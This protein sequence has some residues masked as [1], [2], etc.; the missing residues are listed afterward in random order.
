M[1]R[2]KADTPDNERMETLA[3]AA[4][5]YSMHHHRE[6]LRMETGQPP[7]GEAE[8]KLEAVMEETFTPEDWR[9]VAR[10]MDNDPS[11]PREYLYRQAAQQTHHLHELAGLRPTEAG[12]VPQQGDVIASLEEH[13]KAR[14]TT[15]RP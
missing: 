15:E 3:E 10:I 4:E 13:R 8:K 5:Y 1:R 12:W 7:R 14:E 6:R 2:R 11:L 9:M